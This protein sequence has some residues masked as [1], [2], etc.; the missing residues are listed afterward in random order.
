MVWYY[1]DGGQQA[2]P[3]DEVTLRSFVSAGK[4]RPDT[5]VWSEGMKEWTPYNVATAATGVVPAGSALQC[6]ECG[7]LFATEDLV[8]IGD[9]SICAA[10]KPIA[11]QK[12]KEGI[13]TG[14]TEF[15]YAGFWMRFLAAFIDGLVMLPVTLPIMFLTGS[16]RSAGSPGTG[17]WNFLLYFIHLAYSVFF[18]GRSGSTLG[19]MACGIRVV[20]SNGDKVTYLRAFGRWAANILAIFIGCFLAGI[21]LGIVAA[22]ALSS[23][24]R[25]SAMMLLVVPLAFCGALLGYLSIVFDK[26]KRAFHDYL[27]DTRVVY[28]R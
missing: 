15:R 17:G 14:A 26:Q 5:P 22:F 4:I 8:Q 19:M 28:K 27:C 3:V 25:Y 12:L 23:H 6:A 10:C 1:I 21:I 20:R 9:R 24:G 13:V 16:V 11:V 7:G 2:G 18:I